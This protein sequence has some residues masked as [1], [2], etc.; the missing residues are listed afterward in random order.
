MNIYAVS[1]DTEE[2]AVV[3]DDM[4]LEN[5]C[6]DAAHILSSAA[7]FMFNI[8]RVFSVFAPSHQ[9]CLWARS[10]PQNFVWMVD[11]YFR[12]NAEHLFRFGDRHETHAPQ[13]TSV[14]H[15]SLMRLI[16]GSTEIAMPDYFLNLAE[17]KSRSL[18]FTHVPTHEAYRLFLSA[19]WKGDN[20]SPVWTKRRNPK[21]SGIDLSKLRA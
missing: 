15:R 5:S 7:A 9:L 1:S 19:S 10:H 3:L 17:N 20:P 13:F 6:K 11:L 12:L 21:W 14:L 4:R 16:K 18:R 2:C 8:P